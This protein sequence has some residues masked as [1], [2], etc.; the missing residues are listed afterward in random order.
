MIQ[1]DELS[2]LLLD[3]F[4]FSP[5]AICISTVSDTDSRYI[6]VNAAYMTLVGRSWEQLKNQD[7]VADGAAIESPGRQRRQQLLKDVGRFSM[8]EAD[9]RHA[10]G[11]VIATLISARRS[12]L[13]GTLYDI[14]IIMDMSE[15]TRLQ[16][17]VEYY[18]RRAALTDP[19]TDLPNRAAFDRHLE[20]L[21]RETAEPAADVAALAFLDLN[22]FKAINDRHGH[23]MGD[24]LLSA[25]AKRLRDCAGEIAFPARLGGDEFAL[26][27]RLDRTQLPHIAA[28]LEAILTQVF[29][30]FRIEGHALTVGVACGLALQAPGPETPSSLLKRADVQMYAAKGSGLPIAVAC[31]PYPPLRL[32]GTGA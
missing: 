22:G 11:H 18:L 28:R 5:V 2:A 30:P 7:L 10:D 15:R 20:S 23:E 24:K 1:A 16:S 9:I 27:Y 14:E 17:E 32:S 6:R 8:E 12:L 13:N 26:I 3:M 29:R 31:Q 4:E 19:L 21:L 25:V